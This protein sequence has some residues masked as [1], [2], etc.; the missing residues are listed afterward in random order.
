MT[1]RGLIVAGLAAIGAISHAFA[2]EAIP[3]TQEG[4]PD[5]QGYWSNEFLTPLERIEG[6][7]S[8]VVTDAEAETL[9]EG[10]IVTRGAEKFD[11]G[12]AFPEARQ[13]AKVKGGWRTSQV[14]DP[15]DGKLPLT[16][17]ALAIRNS[18]PKSDAR[19]TDNPEDRA[20]SERCLAGPSRAPILSPVE[21]MY[22]QIIQTPAYLIFLADHYAE[23]RAIGI[24]AQPRPADLVSWAGDS[25]A[26]WEGDTLVVETTHARAE[27][28]VR[29]GGVMVGPQ[30]RVIEH[31]QLISSDE[32]LY[33]FTIEDPAIYNLPWTAEYS[34]T[35]TNSPVYEF[36][37][38]E[39]NYGFANILLGS[40]E[41]E[42][43]AAV[44][45]S[46]KKPKPKAKSRAKR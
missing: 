16:Q 8:L 6:A 30:S 19:A 32:L 35:R 38:H 14:I 12:A 33:Q 10:I 3:R 46:L 11:P 7:T 40:R 18:F 39:G 37:C 5:F 34:F 25:T 21:G 23:L 41:V 1:F 42:R 43:H 13:L 44:A 29:R 28:M 15:P 22:N 27:E 45:A 36:A 20:F 31:F 9:V 2:Q 26:K 4:H 17:E 24:G